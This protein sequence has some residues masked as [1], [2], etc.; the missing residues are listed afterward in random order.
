MHA[1]SRSSKWLIR[2]VEPARRAATG[3]RLRTFAAVLAALAGVLYLVH[4]LD[5]SD[6][7]FELRRLETEMRQVEGMSRRSWYA[8]QHDCQG[9]VPR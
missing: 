3:L 7:D 4:R 1:K 9:G 8:R 2:E 6:R 5:T